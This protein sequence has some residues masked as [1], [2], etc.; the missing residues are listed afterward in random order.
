M[1]ERRGVAQNTFLILINDLLWGVPV[2]DYLFCRAIIR[3][4]GGTT[5][6]LDGN[7]NRPE[8]S[9]EETPRTD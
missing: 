2:L 7:G 6:A 3:Q 5:C 1:D 9:H 4:F 8:E